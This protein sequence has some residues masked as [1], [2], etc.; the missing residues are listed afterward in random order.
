MD[1]RK[2]LGLR[3]REL[4]NLRKISRIDLAERAEISEDGLAD[5]EQ[6][7]SWPR[8][9]TLLKLAAALGV[10]VKELFSFLQG[11][12]PDDRAK[13]L[14]ELK[15]VAAGLS[16]RDLEIVVMLVLEMAKR[17]EDSQNSE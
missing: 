11:G 1:L 14:D 6:G 5:I 9:E 12:A 10:H 16:Q 13:A 2:A 8:P 17:G 15:D 7:G 3:V 4:R